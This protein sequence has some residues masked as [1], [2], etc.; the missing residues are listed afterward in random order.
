MRITPD[1]L[2]MNCTAL[3]PLAKK[4]VWQTAMVQQAVK[5]GPSSQWITSAICRAT[6]QAWLA[7]P[8]LEL[9]RAREHVQVALGD[10]VY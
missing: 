1:I 4:T 10:F 3:P 5:P 6:P 9:C 2:A 8:W 7:S